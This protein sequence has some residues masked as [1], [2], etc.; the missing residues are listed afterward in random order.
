MVQIHYTAPKY[1]EIVS[2]AEHVVWDDE[3]LVRIQ[4]SVPILENGEIGIT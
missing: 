1:T 2:M 4:L 3:V